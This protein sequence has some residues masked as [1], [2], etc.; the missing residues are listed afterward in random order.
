MTENQPT[1]QPTIKLTWATI[2]AGLGGA[3]Y[4]LLETKFPFLS[5][6]EVKLGLLPIVVG[7]FAFGPGWVKAEA[8]KWS[9]EHDAGR[10]WWYLLIAGVVVVGGSVALGAFVF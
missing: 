3:I 9:A 1:S 8:S 5:A 2:G 10:N 6:T 7:A 4:S